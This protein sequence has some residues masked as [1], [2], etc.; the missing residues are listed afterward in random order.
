MCH[1]GQCYAQPAAAPAYPAYDY[2]PAPKVLP[3]RKGPP[4]PGYQL[5]ESTL[6]W[7]WIPGIALMASGYVLAVSNLYSDRSEGDATVFIP[8]IGP[9]LAEGAN[10][11]EG[12]LYGL[13]QGAGLVLTIVGL[14]VKRRRFVRDDLAFDVQIVPGERAHY[15]LTVSGTL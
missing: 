4:P 9:F 1:Q 14:T 12:A 11:G 6:K 8:I 15:G 2:T 7:L 5:Q 13:A 10:D 3:Y